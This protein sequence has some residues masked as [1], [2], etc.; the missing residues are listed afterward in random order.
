[1]SM[2]FVLEHTAE[3]LRKYNGWKHNECGVQFDAVPMLQNAGQFYIAVDDAG[4]ET[5]NDTTDSIK[6]VLSITLGIWRRSEHLSQRDKRGELKLPFDKYL[7][8]A[9]TLHDLER[10]VLIP[11][12]NGIHANYEYVNELNTRYSLPDPDNGGVF[13]LCFMYKGRGRIETYGVDDG[14]TVQT[15]YGYR[16]RFRGLT[17]EQRLR[18]GT[19]AQG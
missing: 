14:N 10:A 7:A 12:L 17:R 6:E 3:W 9:Y 2:A 1:M 4:V 13:H 16:L 11:R 8:G 19:Q 18:S 15:W 5:G